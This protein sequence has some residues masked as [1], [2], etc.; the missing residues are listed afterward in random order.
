MGAA[1]VDA[2][3][4]RRHGKVV[5]QIGAAAAQHRRRNARAA[6]GGRFCG[7]I[8]PFRLLSKTAF[9]GSRW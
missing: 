5:G 4:V 9:N 3:V 6:V 8:S 1:T 7:A 2:A